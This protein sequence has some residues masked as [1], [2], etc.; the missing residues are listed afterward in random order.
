MNEYVKHFQ[1]A[2]EDANQFALRLQKGIDNLVNIREIKIG[3][4]EKEL[5][6]QDKN[7][8]SYL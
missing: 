8:L 3:E 7:L 2:V 6:Y 1:E 5:V 4:T